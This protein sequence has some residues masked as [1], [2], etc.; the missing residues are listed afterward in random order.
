MAQENLEIN[1]DILQETRNDWLRIKAYVREDIARTLF[2]IGES[3]IEDNG[4]VF[5]A[6]GTRDSLQIIQNCKARKNFECLIQETRDKIIMMDNKW[7]DINEIDI[8][9]WNPVYI[10][11]TDI[12]FQ[13]HDRYDEVIG[14]ALE[15]SELR[16]KAHERYEEYCLQMMDEIDEYTASEWISI[17]EDYLRFVGVGKYSIGELTDDEIQENILNILKW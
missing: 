11:W 6:E 14:E 13:L 1:R 5:F 9:R 8:S 17:M 3:K 4:K 2:E 12:F 16:Y 15:F 10:N 7:V